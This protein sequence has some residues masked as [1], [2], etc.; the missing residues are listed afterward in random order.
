MAKKR[1]ERQKAITAAD[2]AFS[3]YIRER[4]KYLCYTCGLR[5]REKDGIM[6]CGHLITRAKYSVRW[7]P[8]NAQCQCKSCNMRHEFQPEIFTD[9]W[10]EENGKEAYHDLVRESNGIR[11]FKTAD[12]LE[13]AG[14]YRT[15]KAELQD[16]SC[17]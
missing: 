17:V 6:Q 15:A 3:E 11:K 1:T 9:K 13:M 16:K 14:M 5:G 12:L 2:K 10:I 7:N 8:I 4:D